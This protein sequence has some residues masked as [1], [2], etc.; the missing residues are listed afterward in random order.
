[1]A[2]EGYEEDLLMREKT[3]KSEKQLAEAVIWWLKDQQWEIYQEVPVGNGVADIVAKR[4]PVMWLI[5]TKL[6]M[7][8]QLLKQL[9]DR[10]GSVHMTSAAIPIGVRRN[11]PHKLLRA[12][13][14]GLI[15]VYGGGQTQEPLRPRFFRKIAGVELHE[16]Q[17]TFCSAGSCSGGHWTPFKET[18]RNVRWYVERHPGCTL[19]DM[20]TNIRHHYANTASAKASI[21]Y[22]IQD[23]A[24]KDIRVDRSEGSMKLYPIEVAA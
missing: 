3:F 8:F 22:W 11:I 24:I 9:D 13:G 21:A 1:M 14:V 4:G 17:K 6:S 18:A 12:L 7:S 15:N 16:E 10:V 2:R 19:N 23:G 5:E 20:L